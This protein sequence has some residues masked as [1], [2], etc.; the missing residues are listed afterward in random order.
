LDNS[1]RPRPGVKPYYV[2]ISE[3]VSALCDA[4][5]NNVGEKGMNNKIK[6]WTCEI[7]CLNE[8]DR[9]LR[10]TEEEKTWVENKDG[11]LKE[12]E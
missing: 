12:V 4:I 8:L 1:R 5:V 10:R 7:Q 3:R 6:L 9:I 2:A 11:T